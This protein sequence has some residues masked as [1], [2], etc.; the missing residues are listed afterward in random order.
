MSHTVKHTPT[1]SLRVHTCV[2][3]VNK[4]SVVKEWSGCEREGRSTIVNIHT[5]SY[6]SH[7]QATANLQQPFTS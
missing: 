7:D 1:V 5:R 4:G 3:T 6:M 2:M